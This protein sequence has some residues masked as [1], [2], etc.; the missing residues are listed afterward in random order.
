[1]HI[2]HA[3]RRCSHPFGKSAS[4][5]VIVLDLVKLDLLKIR[6]QVMGPDD[7]ERKMQNLRSAFTAGFQK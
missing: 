7:S 2:I 3:T 4:L 5:D 1:M 6:S